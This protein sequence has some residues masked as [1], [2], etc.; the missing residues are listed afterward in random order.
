V[1]NKMPLVSFRVAAFSLDDLFQRGAV[2]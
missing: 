1:L 2:S